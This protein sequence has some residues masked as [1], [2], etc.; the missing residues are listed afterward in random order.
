[1]ATTP[2]SSYL[3][4]SKVGTVHTVMWILAGISVTIVAL[5]LY[6]RLH[7]RTNYG[8]DDTLIAVAVV[9]NIACSIATSMAAM[10][11]LGRHL[12]YVLLY[13]DPNA[14]V[15]MV[16]DI[17]IAQSFLIM[18]NCFG[19][20]SFAVTLMRIIKDTELWTRGF[21]WFLIASMFI[22]N[23]LAVILLFA[24]CENPKAVWDKSVESKC[25]PAG[26]YTQFALFVGG[27]SGAVDIVLALLPWTILWN[28]QM[29]KREKLGVALAMS[30]GIFAG[31]AA[32][33]KTVLL[34]NLDATDP[35]WDEVSLMLWAEAEGALTIIAASIPTLRPL[36]RRIWGTTNRSGGKNSKDYPLK[37]VTNDADMFKHPQALE[38]TSRVTSMRRGNPFA[39]DDDD[40]DRSIL[41][42]GPRDGITVKTNYSVSVTRKA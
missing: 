9:L 23:A 22:A 6:V 7:L 39:T 20:M 33:V 10:Q 16:L 37:A 36:L 32:I 5:R 31:A 8:V 17:T 4:E 3:A 26:V 30:L 12:Q 34:P 24:Q 28:L 27:Y 38:N 11:G 2:S 13:L 21:L 25:W 1:M 35:S 40:S 14:A 15:Q 29:K 19:K 18:G 41:Q 42:E